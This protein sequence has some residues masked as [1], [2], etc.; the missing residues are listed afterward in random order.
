MLV[1]VL[2]VCL[3]LVNLMQ[4][5][6]LRQRA[7]KLAQMI[8]QARNDEEKLQELKEYL[9]SDDYVRKWAVENGR[10]QQ[11]DVTWLEQNFPNGSN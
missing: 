1:L 4:M 5:S 8:D 10:I 9:Q 7:D 11:D 2:L 3:L 6:S